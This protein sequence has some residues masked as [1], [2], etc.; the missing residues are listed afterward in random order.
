MIWHVPAIILVIA[1]ETSLTKYLMS[2]TCVSVFETVAWRQRGPLD[3]HS[4]DMCVCVCCSQFWKHGR[5]STPRSLMCVSALGIV[6]LN[7]SF[8]CIESV[9]IPVHGIPQPHTTTQYPDAIHQQ[10]LHTIYLQY[11]TQCNAIRIG[12]V[13][14]EWCVAIMWPYERW[15]RW[16]GTGSSISTLSTMRRKP[17]RLGFQ[18]VCPQSLSLLKCPMRVATGM[19]LAMSLNWTLIFVA[20]G[21]GQNQKNRI[22]H[23]V[24]N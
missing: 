12:I 1:V 20:A 9:H 24:R 11:N 19:L 14:N 2:L 3:K 16:C 15:N 8:S 5:F 23:I 13:V 18:L 22:L 4:G 6:D 17:R 21:L 7:F 10:Q